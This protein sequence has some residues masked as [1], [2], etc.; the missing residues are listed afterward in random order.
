MKPAIELYNKANALPS[1]A[2]QK[3][4]DDLRAKADALFDIAKPYLQKAYDLKP[5]SKDAVNNLRNYYRG[6]YDKAHA[7]ENADKASDLKKQA[8]A[9]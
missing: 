5:K 7:K 6:K 9:L 2:T 1:N 8:D 3:L 4:Y